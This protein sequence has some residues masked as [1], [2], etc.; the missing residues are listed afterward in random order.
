MSTAKSILLTYQNVVS[1]FWTISYYCLENGL[2]EFCFRRSK[3][4][5]RLQVKEAHYEE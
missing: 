1:A 3:M 5:A 2:L 4:D